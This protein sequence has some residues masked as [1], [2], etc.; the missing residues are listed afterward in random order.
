MDNGGEQLDRLSDALQALTEEVRTLKKNIDDI[1]RTRIA[2]LKAQTDEYVKT[3]EAARQA[4]DAQVK[5]YMEALKA[6]RQDDLAER[7]KR[8][9]RY[10]VAVL[11]NAWFFFVSLVF[12][13]WLYS[14]RY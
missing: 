7:R 1:W 10:R 5:A 13:A 8:E 2:Q 6:G 12:M 4:H 14:Q 11:L 3:A 9:R